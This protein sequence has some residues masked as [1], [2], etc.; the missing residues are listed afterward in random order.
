MNNFPA[1]APNLKLQSTNQQY[2]RIASPLKN[3]SSPQLSNKMPP[4]STFTKGVKPNDSG[5]FSFNEIFFGFAQNDPSSFFDPSSNNQNQMNSQVNQLNNN[6]NIKIP[7]ATAQY[8]TQ[9][10][11]GNQSIQQLTS[12]INGPMSSQMSA[13]INTKNNV[14]LDIESPYSKFNMNQKYIFP[15]F[16]NMNSNADEGFSPFLKNNMTLDLGGNSSL[17]QRD[18]GNYFT[19]KNE[20]A[21]MDLNGLGKS[22]NQQIQTP[23]MN[24]FYNTDQSFINSK[25]EKVDSY[26]NLEDKLKPKKKV[27]I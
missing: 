23:S 11:A 21:G 7:H 13:P 15:S 22:D 2:V 19:F 25:A 16:M 18:K 14:F 8:S 4:L 1:I 12:Q 20:N 3:R 17:T 27:K 9:T 5:M 6:N 24:N 10:N 26:S